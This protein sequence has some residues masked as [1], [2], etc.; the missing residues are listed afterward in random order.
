MVLLL[1]D[2]AKGANGTDQKPPLYLSVRVIKFL[3][4]RR[5]LCINEWKKEGLR[6]VDPY[7]PNVRENLDLEGEPLVVEDWAWCHY[8]DSMQL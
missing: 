8:P 2:Y 4:D 6:K 7:H 5:D 3:P 1:A